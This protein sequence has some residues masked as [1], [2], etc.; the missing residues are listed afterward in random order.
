MTG[1]RIGEAM[2]RFVRTIINLPI[3]TLWRALY[4]QLLEV[5]A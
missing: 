1:S 5:K 3:I 4:Y 2:Q